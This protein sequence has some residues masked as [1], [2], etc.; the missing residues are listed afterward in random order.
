MEQGEER[1]EDGRGRGED[2]SGRGKMGGGSNLNCARQ[3]QYNFATLQYLNVALAGVSIG[4]VILQRF[5]VGMIDLRH[6]CR[7]Q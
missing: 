2:G 5:I 3:S 4:N 6:R 7:E 1:W